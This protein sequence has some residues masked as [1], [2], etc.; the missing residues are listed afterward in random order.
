VRANTVELDE[1]STLPGGSQHAADFIILL[2]RLL[3]GV[4]FLAHGW[5]HIFGGGKIA[6]TAR[7]FESLGMRPGAVHAWAA[8]VTELR[9]GLAATDPRGRSRPRRR[10][11]PGSGVLAAGR[12]LTPPAGGARPHGP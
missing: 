10:A 3:L 8:S 11:G 4:A 2:L 6:G 7:W 9:R 12:H 1:G 5:N